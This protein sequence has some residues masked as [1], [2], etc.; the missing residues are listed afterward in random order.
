MAAASSKGV[1]IDRRV[2][3]REL[4]T[5]V[6]HQEIAEVQKVNAA[7]LSDPIFHG[8]AASEATE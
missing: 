4:S 5:L 6:G 3:L 2:T 8:E 7:D 1:A